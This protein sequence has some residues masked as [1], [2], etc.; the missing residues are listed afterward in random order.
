MCYANA[1]LHGKGPN[2]LIIS[3]MSLFFSFIRELVSWSFGYYC[4]L[5]I[6]ATSTILLNLSSYTLLAKS[7]TLLI[8][9]DAAL[10]EFNKR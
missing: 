1:V 10:A 8:I 2:F 5:K 3:F 4:F 9:S 6:L 7:C